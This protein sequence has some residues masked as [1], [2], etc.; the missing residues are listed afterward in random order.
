[1]PTPLRSILCA[2]LLTLI[3]PADAPAAAAAED[4]PQFR[5]PTGQGVSTASNVPVEWDASKNVAWKTPVP[6]RGWSSPVLAGGR[7]Y[8]TT[9]VGDDANPSLRALCV[10]ASNGKVLWDTEVFQPEPKQ[11]K[12]KHKKNSQAS[13]TPI[14]SGDRLYVH[15]GHLGTAALDLSGNVLWRKVVE[16]PPAHGNGGSPV[17]VGE[18]LVFNCDGVTDPFV[19]ALDAKTGDA[20]WRTPRNTPAKFKFSVSTPQI[21]EVDG[22]QQ[23]VSP[24]SG[25]VGGYDPA[26]GRELW[27]V[28]YGNG[29][30]V[31]PRPAFAHGILVVSSGYDGETTF[32]IRPAGAKGDVTGSHVVWQNK[33]GTPMTPSPLAVGDELYLVSDKG[34]A[35]CTDLRT[36]KVHWTH[37]LDGNY[38]AS[39]VAAEG[40]VY[41]QNEEGVGCVIKAAKS[42]F[43]LLAENELGEPSLAS[44]AVTDGALFIR[45]DK[46]LW[47]IAR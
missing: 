22:A 3:A 33:K 43:E 4:W 24:A 25:F 37:R 9:A 42:S 16:H 6:G 29:Y 2:L 45:T 46:H 26:S 15:F 20:R 32:A 10:D 30:S 17:L 41:F 1:M 28:R 8:L 40:R 38:S 47:K 34:I 13:P 39:P 21:I 14:V 44:Y 23:V 12:V 11:A 36:G 5:G 7:V 27:R 31:V 19:V 18:R 35:S